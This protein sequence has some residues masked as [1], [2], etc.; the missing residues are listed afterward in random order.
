V[1]IVVSDAGPLHYL[2]L[3]D[4]VDILPSLFEKV[5]VPAEVRNEL[6]HPHTPAKVKA[7]IT[8]PPAWLV[9]L[10]R[11][12][13]IPVDGLHIGERAALTVAIHRKIHL[14]MDDQA[15][16]IAAKQHGV[17]VFG[18]VGILQRASERN[19]IDLPCTVEK[20]RATNFYISRKLLNQVIPPTKE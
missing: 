19:L 14:L 17:E 16:R 11:A 8:N 10:P 9:L 5:L 1:D 20:L 12:D 18:T 15:G 7:W 2:A 3:I 13:L 4:V 6:L